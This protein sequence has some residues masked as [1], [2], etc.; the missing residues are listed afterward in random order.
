MQGTMLK[1]Q[2]LSLL[3][4]NHLEQESKTLDWERE[5]FRHLTDIT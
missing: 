4:V 1:A 3:L 5:T 2:R